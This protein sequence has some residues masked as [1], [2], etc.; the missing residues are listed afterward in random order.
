[1]E[2]I[3]KTK[4]DLI[5]NLHQDNMDLYKEL[6]RQARLIKEAYIFNGTT[7]KDDLKNQL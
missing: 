2:E 3:I 7:V 6:S 5:E 1:M 4:D